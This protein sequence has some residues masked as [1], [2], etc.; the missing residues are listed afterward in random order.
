MALGRPESWRNQGGRD[1][2]W[3]MNSSPILLI[4]DLA[5]ADDVFRA[6]QHG[7]GQINRIAFNVPGELDRNEG[8]VRT[9]LLH[10]THEN[11]GH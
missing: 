1:N 3:A 2:V 11:G 4:P 9:L 7:L 10:M 6:T 8:R 5:D